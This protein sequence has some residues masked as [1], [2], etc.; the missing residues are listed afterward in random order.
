MSDL[1]GQSTTGYGP[2]PGQQQQPP[3]QQYSGSGP[4]GP[5]AGFWRRVAALLIDSIVVGIGEVILIAILSKSVGIAYVLTTLLS[6]GYYTYF[7]GG[8]RGQTVGGM[9]LGIRVIDLDGG[10]PIGYGRGFVRQLVKII[11]GLVFGLGYLWMLWDR[12]KQTWQDHAVNS[13]VVPVSAYPIP[14]T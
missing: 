6:W 5:R 11:S 12:E 1:Q 14:T 7:E 9:A 10:G 4:S 3:A 8:A 2:P 13:V